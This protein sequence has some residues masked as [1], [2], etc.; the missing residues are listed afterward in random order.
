MI[1]K[2][3]IQVEYNEIPDLWDMAQGLDD[4]SRAMVLRVWHQA[5][6]MRDCIQLNEKAEMISCLDEN[7]T[8]G[9][10]YNFS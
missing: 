9:Q 4:D 8:R 6:D 3:G 10:N 7:Q 5:H 2:N 1:N